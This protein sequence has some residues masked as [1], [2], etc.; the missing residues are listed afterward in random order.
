MTEPTG[1][2][3]GRPPKQGPKLPKRAAHRPT[4][5]FWR[6]PARIH[7]ALALAYVAG[8]QS[9]RRALS[10][11]AIG[12]RLF[13][14]IPE[15]VDLAKINRQ[16]QRALKSKSPDPDPLSTLLCMTRRPGD[17]SLVNRIRGWEIKLKAYRRDP[18]VDAWLS[19]MAGFLC[20]RLQ[21][22]PPMSA[23]EAAAAGARFEALVKTAVD[24][25]SA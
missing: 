2:Q 20:S 4:P 6:D 19:L 14:V 11:A 15:G 9:M 17:L 25:I 22:L 23:T 24:R 21:R 8:G 7:F 12:Q 1:A 16:R 3:R 10:K 18:V 13:P 5:N